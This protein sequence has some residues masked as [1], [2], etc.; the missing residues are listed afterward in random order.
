MIGR[1]QFLM[2]A[3]LG[4]VPLPLKGTP[5]TGLA[6]RETEPGAQEHELLRE[7]TEPTQER[8]NAQ[9]PSSQLIVINP[10]HYKYSGE[11]LGAHVPGIG[12]E[13]IINTQIS[14]ALLKKLQDIGLQ[15]MVTRDEQDYLPEIVKFMADH[16]KRLEAEFDAYTGRSNYR[17]HRELSRREAI[18]QLGIMRYTEAREATAMIDIHV[19]DQLPKRRRRRAEARG[20]SVILNKTASRESERLQRELC[21]AL[22]KTLPRNRCYHIRSARQGIFILGNN[23][24]RFSV[25]SCLVECGFMRQLYVI[26]GNKKHI[27]DPEVQDIYA[28]S[29]AR[30]LANNFGISGG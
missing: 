17:R 12:D 5:E 6:R 14:R 10:G 28:A 16:N 22:R 29:L 23:R 4:A 8:K 9:E 15:A 13:Y 30:G 19:D 2:V 25:P 27:C 3:A 24:L 11:N 20:F 26:D 1:R 21:S 18:L 7:T